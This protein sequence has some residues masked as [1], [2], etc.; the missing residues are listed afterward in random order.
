MAMLGFTAI[1]F[2]QSRET[3]QTPGIPDRLYINSSK[4]LAVFW[5]AKTEIGKQSASQ[6][7]FQTLAES[8]GWKYLLGTS[9]VL[10]A[11]AREQGLIL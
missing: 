1:R 6:R 3:R 10:V 9:D 4:R 5:E 8:V 2:S 7:A 11:W